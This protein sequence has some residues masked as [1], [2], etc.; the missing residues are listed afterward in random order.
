MWAEA[1]CLGSVLASRLECTSTAGTAGGPRD[2]RRGL[3]GEG[4]PALAFGPLLHHDG[5][6]LSIGPTSN[7]PERACAEPHP[8]H[9]VSSSEI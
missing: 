2:S 1:V 8:Q 7:L 4:K 6:A 3:P 9:R 5:C